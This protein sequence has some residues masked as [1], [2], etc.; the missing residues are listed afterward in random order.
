MTLM[1]ALLPLSACISIPPLGPG[2]DRGE[3]SLE[4]VE[5]A[6]GFFT[7]NQVLLLPLSGLVTIGDQRTGL[8]GDTGMLVELQDRLKAA[9]KNKH[10]RAVVLR[11]DSPGGTVT[12]ADLIHREL[13]RFKEETGLPVI[14]LLSDTAASG[15]I[16][17]AMAAD[18]IYALPTTITGSIGVIALYPNLEGLIKKIG[19]DVNVIKAGKLKDAG[20]PWREMTPEERKVFQTIV[21]QYNTRFRDVIF[22]GRKDKGMTREDLERVADGRVLTPAQAEEAKLIDGIRYPEE[23]YQRA[24][25]RA[26]VTDA[27]VVS[28]EYPYH[29]RGNIY[30]RADQPHPR[31][32]GAP[33]TFNLF[34]IQGDALMRELFGARFL[35]LWMP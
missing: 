26:G 15:G 5:P 17:I 29:Y 3:V 27:T 31:A 33:M 18:E 32:N 30:A 21:D 23:V 20:S 25:E 4:V 1:T 24:R 13:V 10:I 7:L 11:I 2:S 28:Y 9:K 22:E 19:V 8:G 35:Y 34:S 16:Y 6:K 12:A 14:A